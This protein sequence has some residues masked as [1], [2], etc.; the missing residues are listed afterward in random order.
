VLFIQ[1]IAGAD[2]LLQKDASRRY[3][4]RCDIT[5]GALTISFEDLAQ[6]SPEAILRLAISM[7]ETAT[8]I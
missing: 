8:W 3:V 2:V 1:R 4:Y 6:P 7:P 5:G